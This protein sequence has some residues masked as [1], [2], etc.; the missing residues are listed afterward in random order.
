MSENKSDSI[1]I[2]HFS[3][4]ARLF[5][6]TGCFGFMAIGIYGI[7]KQDPL[8]AWL[9]AAYGIIGFLLVVLPCLCTHCP[10]PYKLSTCLFMPP[11]LLKKFYPY[12]GPEMSLGGKIATFTIMAGMIVIPNFWLINDLPMLLIYWLLCLP[13]AAGIALHY[14]K[15]CRH[16]GCPMNRA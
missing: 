7:Y 9:Y 11:G 5:M 16:F 2:D 6:M 13:V 15:Y 14:C 8:W 4:K 3:L 12:Q 1:L 10:Y